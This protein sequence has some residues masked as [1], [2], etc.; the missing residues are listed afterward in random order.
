M[1]EKTVGEHLAD[2][3]RYLFFNFILFVIAFVVCFSFVPRLLPYFLQYY[4]LN[5]ISLSPLE[6]ITTQMKV[7]LIIGVIFSFPI[8]VYSI[9]H[10]CKEF[11][12][13]KSIHLVILISYVLGLIGFFLGITYMSKAILETMKIMT[14]IESLWNIS[15]VMSL[16]GNV[17][18][19]MALTFQL[20]ILI[21][22]LCRTGLISYEGY[23]KKRLV[24][25]FILLV[26]IA[27]ITPDPT[28]FSTSLLFLPVALSLEG[29]FQI[30]RL[31]K[32]K[33]L[34]SR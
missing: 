5:L 4:N 28:M 14:P 9:Y 6:Y 12:Y 2:L 33:D 10:Y 25:L 8:I 21:P 29:G 30:S 27:I 3:R 32:E 24:L 16:V 13:I 17:G 23:K 11:V 15:S 34:N 1:E 18:L 26:L 22:I 31:Y 20:F 19:V 7:S